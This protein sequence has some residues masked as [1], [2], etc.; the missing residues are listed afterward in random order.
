MR[1]GAVITGA[2]S[3]FPPSLPPLHASLS[4][5]PLPSF[6]CVLGPSL[7]LSEDCTLAE[8]SR[9]IPPGG[10]PVRA[11]VAYY[12]RDEQEERE[13][14]R[15]TAPREIAGSVKQVYVGERGERGQR[16]PPHSILGQR[17]RRLGQSIALPRGQKKAQRYKKSVA[18]IPLDRLGRS[19][20]ILFFHCTMDGGTSQSQPADLLSRAQWGGRRSGQRATAVSSAVG[21]VK[22]PKRHSSA[23][24]GPEM[25]VHVAL[26]RR[27][28]YVCHHKAPKSPPPYFPSV[29][30]VFMA[31]SQ[32][33][34]RERMTCLSL[35]ATSS[36]PRS[37]R[38]RGILH[39]RNKLHGIDRHSAFGG[40]IQKQR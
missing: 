12:A 31:Q 39:L 37:G 3:E 26:W 22:R 20:P 30:L 29:T 36:P 18:S 7:P 19:A 33:G 21:T 40:Q 4:L 13:R 14:E 1:R 25:A 6:V 2:S 11:S 23:E 38:R 24:V 35:Y 27:S 16:A 15:G 8:E 17:G 5:P 32:K 9:Y 10:R 28:R 34:E